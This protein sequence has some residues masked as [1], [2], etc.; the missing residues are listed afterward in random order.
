MEYTNIVSQSVVGTYSNKYISPRVFMWTNKF[1]PYTLGGE[2]KHSFI[3]SY[4]DVKELSQRPS[5]SDALEVQFGCHQHSLVPRHHHQG[6]ERVWW[7]W[8][9]SLVQLM[10]QGGI[11]T[12][13]SDRSCMNVAG[14]LPAT[15]IWTWIAYTALLANQI[16]ALLKRTHVGA[17]AQSRCRRDMGT[18]SFWAPQLH[19]TSVMGMGVPIPLSEIWTPWVPKTLGV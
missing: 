4:S 2:G 10:P 9:K 18:P 16:R 7:H 14:P 12:S 17:C 11:C 15:C 19:I 3:L 13:Q 8:A 6:G 1:D 5:G